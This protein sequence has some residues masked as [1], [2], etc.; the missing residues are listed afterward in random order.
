MGP[1]DAGSTR[2]EVI[3]GSDEMCNKSGRNQSQVLLKEKQWMLKHKSLYLKLS[4]I[5]TQTVTVS[6]LSY[7]IMH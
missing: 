1:E 7:L 3:G 4:K 5:Y 6:L 2:N